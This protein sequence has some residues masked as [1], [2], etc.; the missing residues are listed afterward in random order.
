MAF[1]MI[2]EV[3]DTIH[4]GMSKSFFR[5]CLEWQTNAVR[6]TNKEVGFVHG[7]IEHEFHG[8]KNRRYYRE[9]WQILV[10]YKYDPD[11]DLVYDSQG[12]I[13]L[14]GKPALEQA[15]KMYNRSRHEDSIEEC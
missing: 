15:I 2:G 11:T 5:R 7:R 14:V 1:A 8:P 4:G 3:M 9:R 13:Q 10:D 6:I 12:L